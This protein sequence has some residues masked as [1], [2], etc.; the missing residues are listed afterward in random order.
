MYKPL[1]LLLFLGGP[2]IAG[3]LGVESTATMTPFEADLSVV[4][5]PSYESAQVSLFSPTGSPELLGTWSVTDTGLSADSSH[6]WEDEAGS[7]QIALSMDPFGDLSDTTIAD[8]TNVGFQWE[9]FQANSL[10]PPVYLQMNDSPSVVPEMS[11]VGLL[12][13]GLLGVL[14]GA[15]RWKG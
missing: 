4:F 13:L 15:K 3:G 14:V 10:A 12:C 8:I 11:A 1:L 2:L 6:F 5:D 9:M 7:V